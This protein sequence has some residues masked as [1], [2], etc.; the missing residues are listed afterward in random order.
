MD[1]NHKNN[2][3]KKIHFYLIIGEGIKTLIKANSNDIFKSI[4]EQFSKDN[5]SFF[6]YD[7]ALYAGKQLNISET[8]SELKIPEGAVILIYNKAQNNGNDDIIDNNIKDR[9]PIQNV[10]EIIQNREITTNSQ[11]NTMYHKH[12]VVLLYSNEDW[13][14]VKCLKEKKNY[15][16]KYHC[17]LKECKFNICQTC[18]ENN[19]KYPLT[20]FTHKQISLYKYK[21]SCHNHPLLYC[22][23]SRYN[24]NLNLWSC[25]LCHLTFTNRIWSFYCTYCDFDLCLICGRKII[26]EDYQD[27]LLNGYGIKINE[28]EHTL[29]FLINNK[30]WNCSLCSK[31]FNSNIAKFYCSLCDYNVC[32]SCK[33]KINNEP[34]NTNLN[35][36]LK[37]YFGS[38]CIETKK[39]RHSLIYCN[40]SRTEN[41]TYWNCNECGT[42]YPPQSWSFYCTKCD[43]DL[44]YNCFQKLGK[45]N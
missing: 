15:E 22:R 43:Y 10:L 42:K 39:H 37:N 27:H 16:P 3:S 41:E 34:K 17:S 2:N 8:I 40:T 45:N 36:A 29:I 26:P 9:Q 11:V 33:D 38:D 6:T 32:K 23:S 13:E 28:H 1:K 7:M 25:N 35:E 19:S 14:C 4:L 31:S 21:F 18:I 12:G 24:N 5:N 44:C 30:N 20:D